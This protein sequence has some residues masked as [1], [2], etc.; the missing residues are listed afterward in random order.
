MTRLPD[1]MTL[2]EAAEDLGLSASTLRTQ[3]QLGHLR[4][5]KRGRD[6]LISRR[7]VERYRATRLGKTGRQT[8]SADRFPRARKPG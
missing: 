2:P 8:G 7:E 6:W 4:G 5:T 3:M 1:W